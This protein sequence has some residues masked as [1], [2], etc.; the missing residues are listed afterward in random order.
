M[1]AERVRTA[2]PVGHS[3]QA[4][5]HSPDGSTLIAYGNPR[6]TGRLTTLDIKYDTARSAKLYIRLMVMVPKIAI[7]WRYLNFT[8]RVIWQKRSVVVLV[9]K[10]R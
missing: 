3:G 10:Y 7:I 4:R 5:L 6:T 9:G 8:V 1:P 2:A